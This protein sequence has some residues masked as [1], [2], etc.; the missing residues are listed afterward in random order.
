MPYRFVAGGFDDTDLKQ[1]LKFDEGSGTINN[2]SESSA[3]L[4]SEASITM[5]G[6]TYSQGSPL[7]SGGNSVAFDGVDDTGTCGTS[8]SQFNYLHNVDCQWTICF[9]LILRTPP[10]GVPFGTYTSTDG[11]VSGIRIRADSPND[12]EFNVGGTN[13]TLVNFNAPSTFVPDTTNWYFYIFRYDQT[14]SSLN[15]K[16]TR[17]DANQ[18]TANKTGNTPVNTDSAV[19]M[20]FGRNPQTDTLHCDMTISEFSNWDKIMS[21]SDS[22]DLY[23]SGDGLEIY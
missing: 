3:D 21:A 16:A 10:Y 6:G 12:F 2:V 11:S 7:A 1:Y 15:M 19:P 20:R 22:A 14:L 23:N 4:G 8:T 5:S 9:W 18:A 13:G 17:N